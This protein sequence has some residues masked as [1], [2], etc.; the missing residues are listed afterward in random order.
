MAIDIQI[1]KKDK[2]V[3]HKSNVWWDEAHAWL[4]YTSGRLNGFDKIEIQVY[5]GVFTK[6]GIEQMPWKDK[7]FKDF[8]DAHEW[9]RKILADVEAGKYK[10]VFL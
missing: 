3:R 7:T 2:I 8:D 6:H 5:S 4:T 1:I 10:E 9:L